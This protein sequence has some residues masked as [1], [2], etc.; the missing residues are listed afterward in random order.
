MHLRPFEST[1]GMLL[2]H[3][4]LRSLADAPYAFG[5]PQTLQE[6]G[7]LPDSYWH[8]LAAELGGKDPAWRDRWH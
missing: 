5:G 8:Q 6:E 7:A 4:R 2:K 1:D 3:V